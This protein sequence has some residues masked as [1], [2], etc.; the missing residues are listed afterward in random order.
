MNGLNFDYLEISGFMSF[1]PNKTQKLDL[2]NGK[3]TTIIGENLDIG[4]GE[5][6]GVGK[7][8]VIDA[9]RYVYFGKSPR[10]SNSGFLNYIEPGAL[11]VASG[12]QR[13]DIAFRVE[14]GENPSLLRLFEKPADDPRDLRT[15]EGGK[16]I[17]EKTKSTKP[18]TTKRIVELLGFDLKLADVL[19]VNEPSDRAC[20]FLKTEDEQRTIIERIFS[21]TILTEKAERLREMRKE[22]NKNLATKEAALI[23]TRQANDRILAQIAALE[24]KSHA[25]AAERD[26]QIKF[27]RQQINSYQG[28]DLEHEITVLKSTEELVRKLAQASATRQSLRRTQE[29]IKQRHDFWEREHT[30]TL[31]SLSAM[32]K[33]FEKADAK[34]DIEHLKQRD[35]LLLLAGTV[36]LGIKAAGKEQD[37]Y[38][39][40]IETEH[41]ARSRVA[42]QIEVIEKQIIELN[43]SKCPTCGQEWSDNNDHLLHCIA[44]L[45]T[46]NADL[47]TIDKSIKKLRDK[48]KKTDTRHSELTA[49]LADLH[50]IIREIP[51]TT[52]ETIEDASRASARLAEM[53]EKFSNEETAHNPHTESLSQ[54]NTEIAVVSTERERLR[55]EMEGLP[56]SRFERLDEA[57]EAKQNLDN[58][59]LQ[60]AELQRI[61]NPHRETIDNLRTNALK[62]VDETEVRELRKLI[63]HMNLMIELMADRDSPIR[64]SILNDWLPQLNQ[65]INTYLHALEVEHQILFDANMTASFTMNGKT[66]GFGN[67]STGQRLRVWLA[68]NLAFRHIFEMINYPINLLFVDEVLD[69][70]MSARGA[71]VSYRLLASLDK[72]IF[73]ISHRQELMDQSDTSIL[74]QLENGLTTLIQ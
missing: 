12:A 68:T 33:T 49:Q 39:Q 20:F 43:E 16:F 35:E 46:H 70:G 63:E 62:P 8:A 56:Q 36:K 48:L 44:E 71:E 32:I 17:F 14:R 22:E 73:L 19:L 18:E 24:E 66:L 5:R 15:K 10:V 50:K 6:N 55:Q 23:A 61:E 41:A 74:V 30:D 57:Q 31:K 27:V 58:L 60:F 13:D 7:S 38:K 59:Q 26:R 37:G 2:N 1:P 4:D 9:L 34:A 11:L 3:L 25:W 45:D 42:K 53:L 28:I 52:Y 47:A 65:R 51:T 40:Q 29:Q 54:I 72:T 21:F 69:K 67:L 64:K